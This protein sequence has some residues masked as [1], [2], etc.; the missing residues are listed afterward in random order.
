M[1]QSSPPSYD[2]LGFLAAQGILVK[3]VRV[4]GG[5]RVVCALRK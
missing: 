2:E 5:C 1:D 4:S 3:G